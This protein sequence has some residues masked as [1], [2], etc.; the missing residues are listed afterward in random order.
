MGSKRIYNVKILFS[1]EYMS[2]FYVINLPVL[3]KIF[4]KMSL[5]NDENISSVKYNSPVITD[6]VMT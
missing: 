2:V 1:V 5:I 3:V 6:S 4:N